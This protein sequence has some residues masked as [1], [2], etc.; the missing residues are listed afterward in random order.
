VKIALIAA[1]AR[2]LVIGKNGALPWHIAEDLKRFKRLTLGRPV[3]MGRRTWES[4]GRPL[5][6][7]RNVV[8]TSGDLPGVEHYPSIDAA[9]EALRDQEVV[10]VI[11]GATLY[12]RLLEKADLLYL[13][14]LTTDV[15]GDTAFPP[16]R[17]LIGPMFVETAREEHEG[18][19][20]VDYRRTGVPLPS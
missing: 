4:L 20:F 9:L 19:A 5:P 3:L 17:H 7:R 8:V 18:F 2:N 15:E 14:L 16:F 10:F 12:N 6:G 1:V 13:T 11:G